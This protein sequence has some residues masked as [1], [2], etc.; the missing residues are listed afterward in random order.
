MSQSLQPRVLGF[1]GERRF[2]GALLRSFCVV[3]DLVFDRQPSRCFLA[4]ALPPSARDHFTATRLTDIWR[5][6]R[7]YDSF[8]YDIS[9]H[10]VLITSLTWLFMA[11]HLVLWLPHDTCPMRRASMRIQH[12]CLEQE[13]FPDVCPPTRLRNRHPLGQLPRPP[14]LSYSPVA[15]AAS[16]LSPL[17]TTCVH[18]ARRCQHGES[19]ERTQLTPFK[20]ICWRSTPTLPF[21]HI[22]TAYTYSGAHDRR[23]D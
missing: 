21:G 14:R 18:Q 15:R 2:N 20:A 23:R 6:A 1:P 22:H 10:L 5:P 13:G 3:F 7:S 17:C 12:R 8:S 16:L 19:R 4:P 11:F 9:F